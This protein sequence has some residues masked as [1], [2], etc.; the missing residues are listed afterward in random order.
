MFYLGLAAKRLDSEAP[1]QLA[2]GGIRSAFNQVCPRGT[3]LTPERATVPL[4]LKRRYFGAGP[5]PQIHAFMSQAP[6]ERHKVK[7]YS[8]N[9]TQ[10]LPNCTKTRWLHANVAETGL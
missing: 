5:V 9:T 7:P 10:F 4:H 6:L 3:T 8:Y 2:F 1:A